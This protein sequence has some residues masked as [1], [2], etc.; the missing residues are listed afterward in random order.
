MSGDEMVRRGWAVVTG[1]SSGI[2]AATARAL[3]EAGYQVVA[4]ARRV[5]RLEAMARE[6]TG[7]E[8]WPLDVT[9][10]AS[11]DALV[12][13]L[14]DRR[15]TCLVAN[16]GGSFDGAT[17]EEA[18]LVSWTRTYEVNVIGT[19]RTVKSLLPLLRASGDA[20]IVVMS[21]TAGHAAYERGGSY[22]AA[23][24][25]ETSIAGTLRLEL[26][27]EPIRVTEIAPGMVR[28]DEFAIKRFGGDADRAA[29]VYAGVAEPLVAED[30][31][32][33]VAWVATRPSHVNVDRLVIRP[34]AQ[35]AQHKVH[36]VLDPR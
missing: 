36:R 17:V 3:A 2:G 33:A 1:A 25:A 6:T 16:A 9:D 32:D 28:T 18:D 19:V 7:I 21:S 12:D 20:L 14:S 23:K 30:V 31:A 26:N 15:V 5:D 27:A 13:H 11:M 34:V 4:C 35:A 22:V 24:H 29:A 8:A 10:Q